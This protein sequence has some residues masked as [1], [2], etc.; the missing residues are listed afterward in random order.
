MKMLRM[1]L[2]KTT[3]K[4]RVIFLLYRYPDKNYQTISKI[5]EQIVKQK[6]DKTTKIEQVSPYK[7]AR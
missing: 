6:G 1:I 2:L 3:L 4:I 5:R 7:P